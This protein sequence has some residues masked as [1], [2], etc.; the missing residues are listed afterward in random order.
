MVLEAVR[1]SFPSLMELAQE[2]IT[3]IKQPDALR[4]LAVQILKAPDEAVARNL[5]KTIEN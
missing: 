3:H 2:R 1:T 5:F 4:K